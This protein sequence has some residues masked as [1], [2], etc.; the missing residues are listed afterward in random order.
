MARTAARQPRNVP[1][2]LMAMVSPPRLQGRVLDGAVPK[3]PR[4]V[5]QDVQPPVGFHTIGDDYVPSLLVGDVLIEETRAS[6]YGV[7]RRFTGRPIAVGEGDLR[8][9]FNKSFRGCESD[10]R[11]T[12]RDKRCFAIDPT[13][14]AVHI[15]HPRKLLMPTKN[16]ASIFE[17]AQQ[18]LARL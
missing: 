11:G 7:F 4:A 2:K 17:R 12:T 8:T 14:S 6:S 13:D 16:S 9:L 5:D 3:Y 15:R 1:S 18:H 10:T